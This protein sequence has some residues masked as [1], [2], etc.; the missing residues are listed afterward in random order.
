MNIKKYWKENRKQCIL[1]GITFLLFLLMMLYKLTNSPLW[2]DEWVEYN[3]SRVNIWNGEMYTKVITT[4]QPPL[5]NW[6]MHFWL[7]INPDSL[8]W[9]RLFN[10]LLGMVAGLFL[11]LTQLRLFKNTGV[12]C[13][14]VVLLGLC[15][16]WI[17]AIQECSEY[18]LMLLFLF[19]TLYFF[20]RFAETLN[21]R[22]E[23]FFVAGC[24]GAMYSQYGASFVVGPILAVNAMYVLTRKQKKLTISS[25]MLYLISMICFALPLFFR[26][27]LIQMQNNEISNHTA[28][29]FAV[30][31]LKCMCTQFG[32]NIAYLWNLNLS[33]NHM[34]IM[35]RFGMLLM[36]FMIIEICK[37]IRRLNAWN[38]LMI[39]LILG[40]VLHYLLVL[41]HIYAMMHPDESSGFYSR[42]SYFYIP[43][44]AVVIPGCIYTLSLL[45]KSSRIR[46]GFG[47]LL[48]VLAGI[49]LWPNIAMN[50]HKAWDDEFAK[51]WIEREGYNEPTYLCGAM[52]WE[53]FDY[54]VTREYGE[55]YKSYVKDIKDIDKS[56]LPDTFWLWRTNWGG[57]EFDT[58][59]S[60][61]LEQGYEEES[62]ADYGV[63]WQLI[64]LEKKA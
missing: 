14:S 33:D 19:V 25:V 26:Y 6:L 2:G 55:D 56:N 41:F 49:L 51:A 61:A 60:I 44:F 4:F 48:V 17:Y 35:S 31:D 63:N 64:R 62:V 43:V 29:H 38:M 39:S 27:L 23:V 21:F 57:F 58:I 9:F 32:F 36:L 53:G 34:R 47:V 30:E 28:I 40:Y 37:N 18:T 45:I 8:L 10:V 1:T 13:I 20:C 50:W 11:Y 3:Y 16:Q 12:A 5:Y 7:L 52:Y 54:Y 59:E 46:Q 42:Y 22:D 15:Y 24:V